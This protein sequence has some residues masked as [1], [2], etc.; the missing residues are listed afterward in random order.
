MKPLVSVGRLAEL[1]LSGEPVTLLDVRWSVS[2][3]SG[4]DSYA[5]GH[6]PGAVFVDLDKELAAPAGHG[7]RHPLPEPERFAA[8]MRR[9][10]V[11]RHV[12][13]VVYDQRDGLAAARA[14]WLLRHHGHERVFLLDG[15]YDAWVAAAGSVSD[16]D[17]TPAQG[18]FVAAAG[19][20]AVL[21]AG[22]AAVIGRDGVLLDAR[23][24]PRYRGDSEPLDP[25]AG[26]IPGAVS[27]PTT[28]NITADG[29]FRSVEDLQERFTS[30][31]VDRGVEVGVYCGSGVTAAHE[32]FALAVA[33]FDA[34]LYPGS[35][36]HWITDD[37][38][39]VATGGDR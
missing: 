19:S 5:A 6:L 15:G 34:A 12:P 8:A 18:D 37:S 14:W 36:S 23:S 1:L 3:A 11:R 22:A 2:G 38:R 13:V 30:L 31:G 20:S 4:R 9:S 32:V 21:D 35:W 7:G 26:H 28:E 39:P 24:A 17:V 27:A 16:A 29:H 10:G 33:G 25:V